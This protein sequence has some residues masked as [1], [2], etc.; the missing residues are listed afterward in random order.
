MQEDSTTGPVEIPVLVEAKYADF[1]RQGSAF[2]RAGGLSVST[3][4]GLDVNFPSLQSLDRGGDRLRYAG[5]VC[6]TAR[7]P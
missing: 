3:G 6:G 7:R 2:W 1:V 4:G 5:G